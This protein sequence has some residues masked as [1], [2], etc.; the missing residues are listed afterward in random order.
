MN[1]ENKLNKK[2]IDY[3]KYKF[4]NEKIYLHKKR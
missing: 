1:L 2:D 4:K 3:L